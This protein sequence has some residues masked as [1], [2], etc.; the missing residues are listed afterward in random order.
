MT[1]MLT[2][3]KLRTLKPR[4]GAYRIAD[5]N[6]LCIEVRPSGAKVW[7]YRYRYTGKASIITLA[8]YPTMSLAE[9]RGERERLRALVK[10]GGNPAHAARVARAEKLELAETTF[11]A[12]ATE[13]L[14]K[15]AREGL[16]SG[17][18]KRERRLL[19]KDMAAI[20]SLPITD[21]TAPLL[22]ASLRKL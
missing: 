11:G 20:S 9:A 19:E 16:G 21:V 14:A 22:L 1:H 4:A 5:A 10:A 17:S 7:R 6:G 15:R 3:T 2:D 18:V 13:L 12:I 8:E